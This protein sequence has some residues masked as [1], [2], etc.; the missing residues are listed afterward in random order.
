MIIMMIKISHKI[1]YR[2][3]HLMSALRLVCLRRLS[4]FMVRLLSM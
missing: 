3:M 2:Q 1:P 4:G